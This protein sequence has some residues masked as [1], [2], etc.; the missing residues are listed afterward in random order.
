MLRATSHRDAAASDIDARSRRDVGDD[1]RRGPRRPPPREHGSAVA[2]RSPQRGGV[3]GSEFY[4][5]DPQPDNMPTRP[6]YGLGRSDGSIEEWNVRSAVTSMRQGPSSVASA[7][8]DCSRSAPPARPR[9]LL[10][11]SSVASAGTG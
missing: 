4:Q 11:T 1:R 9:T 2:P 3:P 10:P 7:G 5:P 6:G 8:R